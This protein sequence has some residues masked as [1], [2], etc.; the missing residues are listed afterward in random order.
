MLPF[1]NIFNDQDIV[2]DLQV[3]C[4]QLLA[5]YITNTHVYVIA[6]LGVRDSSDQLRLAVKENELD[7]A[8]DV[9]E[10]NSAHRATMAHIS[11]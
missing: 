3:M 9:I 6:A 8:L 7:L 5:A 11:L 10:G 2:L 4:I 1:I